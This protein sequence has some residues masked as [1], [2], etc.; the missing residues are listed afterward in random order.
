M[1]SNF[2]NEL[3]IQEALQ[4]R[5]ITNDMIVP[6][7]KALPKNYDVQEM[8][9]SVKGRPIYSVKVGS[10]AQRI[11]V[12]S[13]M[14]G[15]ESTTTKALFDF[16]KYAK[17]HPTILHHLT[18][19]IIPILN[20]DG[21]AA[22]R[23]TN[24]NEVDLNRDAQNLSQPESLLLRQCFNTFK[25]HYCFN[26]HDQRSIFNV[27][28]MPKPATMA[29]LA[30]AADEDRSFTHSRKIAMSLIATINASL[31]SFIP[32]QV[33][34]YDDAFNPNCVGDAFQQAGVPTILFEAGHYPNDYGR[35]TTRCFVLHAFVVALQTIAS[36]AVSPANYLEY[37]QIPNN[38]KRF[39]DV[40]LRNVEHK[41]MVTDIGVQYQ[42]IL[43]NNQVAFL[44]EVVKIEVLSH[45]YGHK[46]YDAKGAK[47][48]KLDGSPLFVGL[49]ETSV[50]LNNTQYSLL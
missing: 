1:F 47:I 44:P 35:D 14:H 18:L 50:L 30:P 3:Y 17:A 7:L 19:Y 40:V 42:E 4:H 41:G 16:F 29:F 2:E 32:Q 45:F 12:W 10:G 26:M 9:T 23:R 24:A 11:L 15:N 33:A 48:S 27:G 5:Y 20:P 36:G 37:Q 8:G 6:L 22:Y 13:Q 25:P 38:N 21:A 39:L 34:L 49:K 43:K 46:D 31:Q 28:N